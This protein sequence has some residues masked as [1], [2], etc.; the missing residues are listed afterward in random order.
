MSGLYDRDMRNSNKTSPKGRW[1]GEK[2]D[3]INLRSRNLAKEATNLTNAL[4]KT[5][6]ALGTRVSLL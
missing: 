5:S 1:M 4:K 3:I 6:E 2:L